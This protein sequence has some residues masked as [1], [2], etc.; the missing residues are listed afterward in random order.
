ML[1]GEENRMTS[2]GGLQ[3]WVRARM[4]VGFLKVWKQVIGWY[5]LT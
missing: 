2:K 1:L 3:K 5:I 4:E